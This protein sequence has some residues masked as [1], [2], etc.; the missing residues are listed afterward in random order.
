M[1]IV[2]LLAA[3][4]AGCTPSNPYTYGGT[5]MVDHFPFDGVRTWQFVSTDQTV[6]YRLVAQMRADEPDVID[7]MNVYTV[8]YISDCVRDEQGC[9]DQEI[10]RTISWASDLVE[11]VFI[12]SWTEGAATTHFE[13]PLMVAGT[14]MLL[15]DEL[16]TATAGAT[17]TSTLL[18]FEDCPVHMTVD[19]RNCARFQIDDGDGND[20]TGLGLAG[21]YWAVKGYNVV[22]LRLAGEEGIWQLSKQSCEGQCDGNW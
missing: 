21:E 4:L 6:P 13:P 19:W 3:L 15:G 5:K 8:D 2:T 10:L 16:T 22:A 11:G 7:G 18:D 9:V 20:L 1:R 17:W 14:E 12:Y